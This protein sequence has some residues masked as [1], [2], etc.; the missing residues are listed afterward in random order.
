MLTPTGFIQEQ[1]KNIL[2]HSKASEATIT[3]DRVDDQV[4]LMITDNGVGFDPKRMAK[5][6]G[7][8]SIMNRVSQYGGKLNID[9]DPGSGCRLTATVPVH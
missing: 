3:L 4:L 9:A 5:G 2:T 7:L 8:A 6:V 1:V